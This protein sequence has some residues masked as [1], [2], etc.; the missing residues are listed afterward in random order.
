MTTS[1][2]ATSTV[3]TWTTSETAFLFDLASDVV[4]EIVKLYSMSAPASLRVEAERVQIRTIR[5][6]QG[7]PRS[8]EQWEH[9]NR[10]PSMVRS[11]LNQLRPD[12]TP[13]WEAALVNARLQ[14]SG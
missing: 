4:A 10:A 1:T 12:L 9:D 7:I 8:V 5:P 6:I 14:R 11:L 3:D 13:T 2:V